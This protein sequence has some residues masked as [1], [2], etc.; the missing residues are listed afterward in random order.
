MSW[1]IFIDN[2]GVTLIKGNL[3]WRL[4]R[5]TLSCGREIVLIDVGGSSLLWV[6]QSLGRWSW[7]AKESYL[8]KSGSVS[9]KAAFLCDVCILPCLSSCW[10]FLQWWTVARKCTL[11]KPFLI[12]LLRML[13]HR[14]ANRNKQDLLNWAGLFP[15][16]PF[17]S[18]DAIWN[19]SWTRKATK[20]VFLFSL[21]P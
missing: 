3:N 21:S 10:D 14:K 11:N 13:Y 19:S 18:K 4:A 6:E 2:L 20:D 9:Q 1:L 7:A 16:P 15:P 12:K 8:N 17:C 5:I